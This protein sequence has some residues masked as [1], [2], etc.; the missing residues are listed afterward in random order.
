M[1]VEGGKFDIFDFREFRL[2]FFRL[3]FHLFELGE[4]SSLLFL[5]LLE[6]SKFLAV[7]NLFLLLIPLH[8]QQIP[9]LLMEILPL[10]LQP[11]Q[12]Y[13]KLHCVLIQSV[14]CL[15]K[16]LI[17]FVPLFLQLMLNTIQPFLWV[18]WF[19]LIHCYFLLILD[20]FVNSFDF[21]LL[22]LLFYFYTL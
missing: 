17:Q 22:L 12:L 20:I 4:N 21:R 16:S 7:F 3:L 14:P 9:L 11:L 13:P 5:L 10:L 2:E 6:E 18:H 19:L 15:S 1:N 8:T